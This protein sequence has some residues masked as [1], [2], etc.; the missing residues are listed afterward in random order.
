MLCGIRTA[1]TLP[2]E[3]C[4]TR[5]ELGYSP[6]STRE[7]LCS[8]GCLVGF[9]TVLKF[10]RLKAHKGDEGSPSFVSSDKRSGVKKLTWSGGRRLE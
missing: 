8:V 9:Q 1:L 5:L 2:L 6:V 4:P 10:M 3:G 7:E